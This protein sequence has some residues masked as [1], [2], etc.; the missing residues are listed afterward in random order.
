MSHDRTRRKPSF[1]SFAA[2]SRPSLGGVIGMAA[3]LQ[4]QT[5]VVIL[6][7]LAVA[8]VVGIGRLLFRRSRKGFESF[9]KP[10]WMA[11]GATIS[12]AMVGVAYYENADP[13]H[14]SLSENFLAE[15]FSLIVTVFVIDRLFRV[16]SRRRNL[17]ARF[18]AFDLSK[19]VYIDLRSVW[20]NLLGSAGQIGK[21]HLEPDGSIFTAECASLIARMPVSMQA[22]YSPPGTWQLYLHQIAKKELGNIDKCLQRY[23]AN[24][25]PEIIWALQKL[26]GSLF[27]LFCINT[28]P[29]NTVSVVSWSEWDVGGREFV[30]CLENL[31][32]VLEREAPEFAKLPGYYPVPP[33]S[34]HEEIKRLLRQW[35]SK[36]GRPPAR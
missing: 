20:A 5:L 15:S 14:L 30:E 26:E 3:L 35:S 10:E 12:I 25:D 9:A 11:Y 22:P 13:D 23:S 32:L 24:M 18:G 2:G 27:F 36:S 33:A 19:R 34:C 28:L 4:S 21:I 16:A 6:A 31:R 1:P 7:L 29:L 17:P 8:V